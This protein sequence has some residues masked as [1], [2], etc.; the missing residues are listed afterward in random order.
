M[1]EWSIA[2]VLKTVE[3]NTSGGSNPSLSAR[4]KKKP[5]NNNVGRLLFFPEKKL[6]NYGSVDFL[7]SSVALLVNMLLFSYA[8]FIYYYWLCCCCQCRNSGNANTFQK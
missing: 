8:V 1:A 4:V 2:A 7:V 6:T 3:G 5:V